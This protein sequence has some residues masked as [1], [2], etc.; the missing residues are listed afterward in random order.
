MSWHEFI[1]GLA[2]DAPEFPTPLWQMSDGAAFRAS[3]P[4]LDDPATDADLAAF[5]PGYK[6]HEIIA[7]EFDFPNA[8]LPI[9]AKETDRRRAQLDAIEQL[10]RLSNLIYRRKEDRIVVRGAYTC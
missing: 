9:S 1:N 6:L 7:V 2:H 10:A 5:A 8:A 3:L 4:A